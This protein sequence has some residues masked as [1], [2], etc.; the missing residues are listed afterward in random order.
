MMAAEDY[1]T[2][3]SYEQEHDERAPAHRH[4]VFNPVSEAGQNE[5]HDKNDFEY[6]API[7]HEGS[8]TT[9]GFHPSVFQL[10]GIYACEKVA[11]HD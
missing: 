7:P 11:S 4:W 6:H 3:N 9:I 1:P 8:V 5:E 10:T 2:Q